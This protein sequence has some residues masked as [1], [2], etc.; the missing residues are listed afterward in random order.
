MN[1]RRTLCRGVAIVGAGRAVLHR[2]IE[3]FSDE[4]H[5]I[6]PFVLVFMLRL[7]MINAREII[8]IRCV[9]NIYS[10]KNKGST[11]Y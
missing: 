3:H 2:V 4:L 11:P 5:C 7:L 9:P 10:F 6:C 8:Y 1:K